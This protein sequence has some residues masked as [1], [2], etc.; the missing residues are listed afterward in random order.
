MSKDSNRDEDSS[1]T[2]LEP[3]PNNP[4]WKEIEE[5]AT[6]QNKENDSQIVENQ[7]NGVNNGVD[8]EKGNSNKENA[9]EESSSSYDPNLHSHPMGPHIADDYG[10]DFGDTFTQHQEANQDMN[11]VPEEVGLPHKDSDKEEAAEKENPD[12]S[13]SQKADISSR[14]NEVQNSSKYQLIPQKY[15]SLYTFLLTSF[16]S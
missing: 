7:Q 12:N 9:E 1:T 8:G 16:L 6:V 14:P 13:G 2:N 3:G 5:E 10:P 15:Y 4:E 11:G